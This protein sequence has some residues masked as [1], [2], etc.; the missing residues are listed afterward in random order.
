MVIHDKQ[1]LFAMGS[2]CFFGVV[3][4]DSDVTDFSWSVAGDAVNAVVRTVRGKKM[5]S[6]QGVFDEIAAA[7]QFPYCFGE[8]W[9]A[10]D[11]CINDLSW[12]PGDAYVFF[13]LDAVK[14]LDSENLDQIK[15]FFRIFNNACKE[16][17]C[18][19]AL[20][21]PWDRPGKPFHIVLQTSLADAACLKNRISAA[22]VTFVDL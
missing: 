13:L 10:L 11:E 18:P 21:E 9:D 2:P 7:L 16:W 14:L 17:S 5:R 3:G 6:E 12:L 1:R 4:S 15:I 8:N 19:I 20:G 22:G